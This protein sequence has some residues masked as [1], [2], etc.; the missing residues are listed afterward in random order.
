MNSSSRWRCMQ[1]PI[2][3][4]SSTF[5]CGEQG[6]RAMSLVVMRHG[7][8]AT[9]FQRQTRL[10]AVEGLDL[11]LLIERKD[12]GMGRRIEIETDDVGSFA[13][14][15]GSRERLKV[16]IRCGCRSWAS[17]IRCTER[18]EMPTVFAI[19]RPVQWVVRG[20]ARH[21]SAPRCAPPSRPQAEA[22]RAC[23]SCRATDHQTLPRQNAAAS[24]TPWATDVSRC[25]RDLLRSGP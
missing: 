24:A 11:A 14:K 9:R 10:R 4:P 25:R 12:H 17:Q 20:A 22:C 1:R 23:A 13:A 18:S 7:L 3:V 16:R 15:R 2:T 5:E 6:R 8:T 19:A 21:R